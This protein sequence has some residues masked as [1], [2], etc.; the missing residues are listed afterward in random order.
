MIWYYY[1]RDID[2]EEKVLRETRRGKA[3]D[4]DTFNLYE[5]VRNIN[6]SINKSINQSINQAIN[7][8]VDLL[9][10][11]Y[12][13]KHFHAKS[14]IN[15]F[16]ILIYWPTFYDKLFIDNLKFIFNFFLP[17]FYPFLIYMFNDKLCYS[18]II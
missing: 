8:S 18:L 12:M 14:I 4:Y 11:F 17:N 7:K 2:N 9:N 10:G 6:Q 16:P 3:L 15:L 5:D 13:R 1:Y